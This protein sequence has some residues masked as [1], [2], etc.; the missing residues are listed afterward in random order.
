MRKLC[1]AVTEQV[2]LNLGGRVKSERE[3]EG[4]RWAQRGALRVHVDSRCLKLICIAPRR[5]RREQRTTAEEPSR[6]ENERAEASGR[7][8]GGGVSQRWIV[9]AIEI[10]PDSESYC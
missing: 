10:I 4:G 6:G 9:V 8:F 7:E 5:A 1:K 3:D 2:R